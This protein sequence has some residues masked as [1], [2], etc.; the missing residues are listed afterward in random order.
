MIFNYLV[1]NVEGYS[2][3]R[4]AEMLELMGS[5][6]IDEHHDIQMALTYWRESID[7][8]EREGIH[9]PRLGYSPLYSIHPTNL[10]GNLVRTYS[11]FSRLLISVSPFP[12]GTNVLQVDEFRTRQELEIISADVE[13]MRI[14][15]LL[16]AERILGN[17]HKDVIFRIMYRGAAYADLQLYPLCISLWIY[18]LQLR[19]GKDSILYGD[20]CFT[21]LALV[22]SYFR[23][24]PLLF[25]AV[26]N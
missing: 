24:F 11:A 2:A 26:F 18:A 9:K 13:L 25:L 14:N 8:R 21:A 15:S 16:M 7:L 22:M 5:T 6:F 10:E 20:S 17:H 23:H 3:E 1:A 19:I 4:R 12:P